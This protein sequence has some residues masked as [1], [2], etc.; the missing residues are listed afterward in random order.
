LTLCGL[1]IS[2]LHTPGH[3]PGSCCF[4][5][6]NMLFSGDTLFEGGVGRTDLPGGDDNA[7][8]KSIAR[9]I[10]MEPDIV[11]CPGHGVST[12]IRAERRYYRHSTPKS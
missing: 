12:T 5:I 10:Q 1:T 4:L 11:V 6:D 8:K 3:T 2:V 9:L 7:L